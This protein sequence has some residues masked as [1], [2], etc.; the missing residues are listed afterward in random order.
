[1]ACSNAPLESI[2]IAGDLCGMIEMSRYIVSLKVDATAQPGDLVLALGEVGPGVRIVEGSGRRTLTVEMTEE[3]CTAAA[4]LIPY[5]DFE[6]D[7]HLNLLRVQQR[8]GR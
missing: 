6:V 3:E 8:A 2:V 7:S 4:R 5:A 1:M